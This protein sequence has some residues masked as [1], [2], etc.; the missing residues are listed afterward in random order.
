[1][2]EKHEVLNMIHQFAGE[3]AGKQVWV[4]GSGDNYAAFALEGLGS[5]VTSTDISEQQL[6][7]K[8]K[9]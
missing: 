1:M 7:D 6:K 8:I 3:R 4:I 9:P 5:A 2:N